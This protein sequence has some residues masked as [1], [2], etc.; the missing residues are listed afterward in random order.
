MRPMISKEDRICGLVNRTLGVAT[1][2]GSHS[3]SSCVG[4]RS[5]VEKSSLAVCLEYYSA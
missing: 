5:N 1:L 4:D 3:R 2:L